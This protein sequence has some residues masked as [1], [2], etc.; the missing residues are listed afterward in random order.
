MNESTKKFVGWTLAVL[1]ILITL[2]WVIIYGT[3]PVNDYTTSLAD[4]ASNELNGILM[5]VAL[6]FFML[7]IIAYVIFARSLIEDSNNPVFGTVASMIIMIFGAIQLTCGMLLLAAI[8][9]YDAGD[10]SNG[11][12]LFM[13]NHEANL[14]SGIILG[15]GLIPLGRAV[16]EAK[17]KLQ[18]NLTLNIVSFG[19]LLA[20]VLNI[21]ATF[22]AQEDLGFFGWI[23]WV[24]V[25][26]IIG[27]N[28]I[29]NK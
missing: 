16:R 8:S 1:P 24:I 25:S 20:G 5:A 14:V 7:I 21:A 13:I 4:M 19:L 18:P 28:L 17:N 6:V 9:L 26:I 29:R 12:L 11:T 23:I 22:V 27:I 3:D 2:F 15:V 10:T